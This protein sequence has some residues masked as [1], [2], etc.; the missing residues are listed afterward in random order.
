[1]SQLRALVFNLAFCAWHLPVLYDAALRS[2]VVHACEHFIFFATALLFWTRVIYSPP[3]RSRLSA[4]AKLAYLGG[5]LVVGILIG[6]MSR[7]RG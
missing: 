1:M 6:M 5:T 7:G 4:P 3:W 2:D